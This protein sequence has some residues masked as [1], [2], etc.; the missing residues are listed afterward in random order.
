MNLAARGR[1]DLDNGSEPI[2]DQ[3]ELAQVRRQARGVQVKSILAAALLT[4]LSFLV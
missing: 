3:A 4:A 1:R 2:A